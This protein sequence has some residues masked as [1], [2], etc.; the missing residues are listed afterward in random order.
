MSLSDNRGLRRHVF[1]AVKLGVLA[2]VLALIAALSAYYTVRRSVAGRDIQVPDVTSLDVREAGELLKRSGLFLEQAAQRNDDRVEEGRILAQ[3]PPPGSAIKPQRKVKVIVSLGNK[4]SAAPELRGLAARRAQIT[5]QQ[6]GTGLGAEIY[7]YSKREPEN[8]VIAQDPLPGSVTVQDGRIALLVSRGA[9][10]RTYVMPD[11]TGRMEA[12]AVRFLARAGLKP[13][14][15]RR[16]PGSHGAPG[17]IVGQDPE[18]GYP[19]RA[20]DLVTLTLA[21]EGGTGG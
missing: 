2:V 7:V 20:G 12:E 18:A 14:P 6:Q 16:D 21:G 4:V 3:D 11:L 15:S 17:T 10:E 8:L 13:V 1:L 9:P 19:V 5:L